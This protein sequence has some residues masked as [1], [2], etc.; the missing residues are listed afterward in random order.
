MSDEIE[1]GEQNL[2]D[3]ANRLPER[4]VNSRSEMMF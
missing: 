4:Q 1:N 3:L 2:D